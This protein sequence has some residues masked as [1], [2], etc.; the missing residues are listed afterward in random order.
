MRVFNGFSGFLAV[1]ESYIQP[2]ALSFQ[3][4]PGEPQLLPADTESVDIPQPFD[5]FD[6]RSSGRKISRSWLVL[7][8]LLLVLLLGQVAHAWRTEISITWPEVRPLLDEYCN[9]MQCELGFP[10]YLSLLSLE[11]SDLQ[12]NPS[13]SPEVTTLLAVIRNHASF[14]Q[15]LPSLLLM[16]TDADEQPI[17]SRVLTPEDYLAQKERQAVFM[18][19]NEIQIQCYL[20]T[21]TNK[22][23]ATGY[24]LELFYP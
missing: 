9:L 23:N 22:L 3:P 6:E 14:P 18:G 2:V 10:R 8:I 16:L 5:R 13:S 4:H 21:D 12:V 1:S 15:E 11:S 20:D 17:A 19:G 7:D 24:K